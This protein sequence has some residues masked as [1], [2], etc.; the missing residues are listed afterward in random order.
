MAKTYKPTREEREAAKQR[1]AQAKSKGVSFEDFF[2]KLQ[3]QLPELNKATAYGW[4]NAAVVGGESK[5]E[6]PKGK[7][8]RSKATASEQL[9]NLLRKEGSIQKR[10]VQARAELAAVQSE[11]RN[12][13]EEREKQIAQALSE[14]S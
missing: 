8:A 4:W 7:Q 3:E 5:S 1:M 12:L 13:W 9:A 11:I 2:S 10:A 6:A 14:E